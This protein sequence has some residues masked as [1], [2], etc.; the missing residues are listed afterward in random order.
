MGT[1]VTAWVVGVLGIIGVVAAGTGCWSS[2]V[3]G[4]IVTGAVRSV[5]AATIGFACNRGAPI[6]EHADIMMTV[7]VGPEVLAGSYSKM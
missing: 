3:L 2:A 7:V 4:V 1:P 5:G 6:E